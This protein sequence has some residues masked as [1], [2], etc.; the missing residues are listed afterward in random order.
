[1]TYAKSKE[2]KPLTQKLLIGKARGDKDK[3]EYFARIDGKPEVFVV[4]KEIVETLEKGSLA[5]LPQ[6]LWDMP[7]I[8]ELRVQR[9]KSENHLKRDGA[10]W[11]ILAP[12]E[13]NA[14]PSLVDPVLKDLGTLQVEA[15]RGAGREGARQVRARQAVPASGADAG[16][17]GEAEAAAGPAADDRAEG[18]QAEGARAA[19]RQADQG[20]R[21]DPVRE[22]GRRRGGFVVNDKFIAAAERDPLDMLDR[23]LLM[24]DAG[25][26]TQIKTTS[27]ADA[28]TLERKGDGWTLESPKAKFPADRDV[29][30]SML[31]YFGRLRCDKYVAY[32]PK[33]D[34]A[35]YGLDKPSSTIK[36]TAAQAG[37][38]TQTNTL[39][40]GGLV[41]KGEGDLAMPGSIMGPASSLLPGDTVAELTH[42]DLDFADRALL[43]F[44]AAG[45]KL[46][47]PEDGRHEPR[48]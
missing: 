39:T 2:G 18:R 36:I 24:L 38:K 23:L 40:L 21:E 7:D 29:M 34:V 11:K 12:F 32:G 15:L 42:P 44:D 41:D 30:A 3:A 26:V 20:R 46:V 25:K 14:V 10:N 16:E 45:V 31:A 6:K 28:Q 19:H 27:G 8:A 33:V 48:R 13:A 37:E 47:E 43:K 17:A 22:A 5:L 35:K 9:E 4:K 1:M